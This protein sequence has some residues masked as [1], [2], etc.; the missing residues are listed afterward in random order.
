MP[1]GTNKAIKT[2]ALRN[3]S[4][5]ITLRMSVFVALVCLLVINKATGYQ[6]QQIALHHFDMPCVNCHEAGLGSPGNTNIGALSGNINE[7]CASAGC[8]NYDP[9]MTHPMGDTLPGQPLTCL[10]CHEDEA[11]KNTGIDPDLGMERYLQT[12]EGSELCQ[13]CHTKLNS[14]YSGN[15][16]WQTKMSAHLLPM[17]RGANKQI[18]A[19]MGIADD[20]SRSCIGC[21]DD[22]STN[23][24]GEFEVHNRRNFTQW[25]SNSNHP[26]GMS[27]RNVANKKMN[28]YNYP[29]SHNERIRLFDGKVGC[30]S[31]HSLYTNQKSFLVQD[32][33]ESALCFQ[34]HNM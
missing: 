25:S 16:H 21:H 12:S 28:K 27:Y 8:H 9:E 14:A 29:L 31:C 6:T 32:N 4:K 2:N 11:M 26:I 5:L 18:N 17:T 10:S 22:V 24:R 7:L 30:G 13:S 1:A 33:H 23:I 3:K 15:Q 20:E 34:C 19:T